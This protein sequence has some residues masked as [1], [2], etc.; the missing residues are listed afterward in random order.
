MEQNDFIT[1]EQ[2]LG[3]ALFARRMQ[4]Q[5]RIS[6]AAYGR[7]MGGWHW[8]NLSLIPTLLDLGLKLLCL[9]ARGLMNTIDFRVEE[10][11]V[12]FTDLPAAFDGLR[13]LH[14]S[15]LHI[16]GMPDGGTK[17]A[18]L[19]DKL[20]FDLCVVT[21][22]FRFNTTRDYSE[23]L[24]RMERLL[25]HLACQ[26]GV[27][28]I[29]GNH[30]FIEKVPDLESFGLRM[31]LNESLPIHREEETL[32][33]IGIDDPHFYGTHDFAA[34]YT[35]VPAEGF[36]V[37]LAHSPEVIPE[38]VANQTHL[39]LSG[40]THGGQICLPGEIPILTNCAS[41]R[42]YIAGRWQAE[43]MSGYTSRGTGSSS[44]PARFFCRPEIT[45]HQL[46]RRS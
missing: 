14:L 9:R 6:A 26:H 38:A 43:G 23:T 41:Q 20:H 7:G 33:L 3:K 29:L 22:D 15:D 11:Q 19:V 10:N 37:L 42:R 46:T 40:H 18:A 45:V 32:Y 27:Y 39:Y 1:L 4:A 34:A 17:L 5:L 31:L 25:P 16:D 30:D 8:E 35:G 24:S 13:I 28:G 2:R 44:Y 36:K 12:A 21:G